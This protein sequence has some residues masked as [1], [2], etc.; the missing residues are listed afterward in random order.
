MIVKK[1]FDSITYYL[2]LISLFFI[3]ILILIIKKYIYIKR[4]GIIGLEHSWNIGNNLIKYAISIKLSELGYIPYIVGRKSSKRKNLSLIFNKIKYRLIKENFNEIKK[5]DYDLLMVNSDQTWR[6]WH[7]KIPSKDKFFYDVAFLR[8]SQKWN[9][10]KF[11]Y[12]ASLGL[13]YWKFSKRDD[14]IAKYLLKNFTGI[15]VR[16]KGSIDLIQKHL[17]Y[18]VEFVLDPTL[19]INK[20]YYLNLIKNYKNDIIVNNN[21]IVV[22]SITNS[23]FINNYIKKIKKAYNY[24]IYFLTLNLKNLI[25]KFIYGISKCKGVITD[26][27]HGTI[28]SIIFNKPFIS[29]VLEYKGIERFNT[30]K[31]KFNLKNRIFDLKTNPNI[32]LL[33]TPLIINKKILNLFVS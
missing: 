23:S 16:E 10:P 6:N 32:N 7:N 31:E 5:S 22:Y 11:V 14:I 15:S 17:G 20:K 18:K 27:Y 28:F 12:G 21:Y 30:L 2:K 24:K 29:F 1:I 4:I 25:E 13:D 3:I 8:F 33:E 26:S 9:L 19:L